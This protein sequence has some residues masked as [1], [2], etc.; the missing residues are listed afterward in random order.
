L[1]DCLCFISHLW[2]LWYSSKGL[3]ATFHTIVRSFYKVL[4]SLF[5][6][7]E[8]FLLIL[9]LSWLWWSVFF[10]F[11]LQKRDRHTETETE[12]QSQKEN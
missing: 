3:F 2:I 10:F 8:C 1:V 6:K 4:F 12:R 11:L 5:K 9:K 7:R